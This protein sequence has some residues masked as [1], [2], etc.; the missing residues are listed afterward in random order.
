LARDNFKTL[1]IEKLKARVAMRCSNPTCR[2]PTSAGT[3]NIEN[4]INI[5]VAA[6]IYAASPLG[7]RYSKKMTSSERASIDN[8]IWLCS[9]CSIEID[10]DVK[11][12]TVSKLHEWKKTAETS[13]KNELGKKLPNNNDAIDTLTAALT[14]YPKNY[15]SMAIPNVHNAMEKSLEKLDP[16]FS[17]KTAYQDDTTIFSI[18]AKENV[19]LILKA[20]NKIKDEYI[21]KYDQLIKHGTDLKVSA[22]EI[23]IEGSRLFEEAFNQKDGAISIL[24]KKIPAIHKLGL[25]Q[26]GTNIFEPIDDIRGEI[27]FGTE[28]FTF[29][30]STWND[31]LKFKYQKF[32]N[33][34]INSAKFNFELCLEQW[35]GKDLNS[36][37]YFEK[38]MTFFSKIV[39]GWKFSTSLEV[40]GEKILSGIGVALNKEEFFINNDS[41]LQYI[42]CNRI[43]SKYM[44]IQLKYKSAL[45][46]TKDEFFK[47]RITSDTFEGKEVYLKNILKNNV[48][49]NIKILDNSLALIQTFNK[50]TTIQFIE[51]AGEEIML[52][53]TTIELPQKIITLNNVLAKLDDGVELNNLKIG[54]EIKV[55][56]VPQENFQ[57]SETYKTQ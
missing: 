18:S 21:K 2:V 45:S 38:I 9:N 42:R 13:A 56:W 24:K 19:S 47:I 10:R 6:H 16:R 29:Q 8:A 49:C 12:Y 32:I 51:N 39:E 30:G 17:I 3:E 31:I 7:P 25:I 28:S 15:V 11:K 22:G 43:I 53:N 40:N 55:E 1:V 41:H 23:S 57:Y 46:Y 35:E 27:S 44:K 54:D 4:A 52:F 36:L 50:P 26:D 37:L 48:T 20:N 14:G 34:D 5:G 33:D